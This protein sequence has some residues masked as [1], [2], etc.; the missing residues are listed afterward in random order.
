[1]TQQSIS[2]VP[3]PPIVLLVE[4]DLD[5][6][7]M[8]HL[9]LESDGYWIVDA[10]DV[11]NAVAMTQD[12]QPDVIV[13]DLGLPGERDGVSFA[14]DLHANPRTAAIPVLALTGR[15]PETLG[16]SAG[17][18]TDVLV[19]PVLPDML[20]GRIRQV[21]A[22]ARALRARSARARERVAELRERSGRVIA[23]SQRLLAEG[24]PLQLIS[25][26]P[27]CGTVL[28]WVERRKLHGV[29]F[30]YFR[31]CTNGC[32]IYCYNHSAR[33]MQSLTQP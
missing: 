30:D 15:D 28:A 7:E 8:Y 6:R 31:P 23:R 5:S 24:P 29:T 11:E 10:S 2:S 27:Q 18:F 3:A 32:G 26:C 22:E 14:R 25:T 16:G 12:V 20:I 33:V 1:M 21:L 4:D 9:A 13:T 19:K 17:L